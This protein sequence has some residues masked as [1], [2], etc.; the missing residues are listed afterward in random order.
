MKRR[1][2]QWVRKAEKD[3]EVARREA[4]RADPARD[5]VCFHCQQAGEKYLKALLQEN[6]APIPRTH[7]LTDVIYL[8]LP[9]DATLAKLHR[10]GKFLKR[11]AVEYRYPGI[12]ART[13]EM[14][15]AVRNAELVRTEVRARLGLPA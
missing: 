1:T 12:T 4:R 2:A 9:F 14:R 8:L 15:S 10:A 6:G 11:F 7:N 13:R 5:V 3:I